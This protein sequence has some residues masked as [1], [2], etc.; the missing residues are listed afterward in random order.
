MLF[1]TTPAAYISSQVKGQ[2]G[3]AAA[4]PYHSHS[5]AR[6][7]PSLQPTPQFTASN[8]GFTDTSQVHYP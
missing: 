3:A 4:S 1:R 5:N 2:R 6:S 7:E 8:P